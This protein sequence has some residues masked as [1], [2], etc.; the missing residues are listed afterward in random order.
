ALTEDLAAILTIEDQDERLDRASE[1]FA[2]LAE[3][4]PVL[5]FRLLPEQLSSDQQRYWGLP[6]LRRLMVEGALE[7]AVQLARSRFGGELGIQ[8]VWECFSLLGHGDFS[9]TQMLDFWEMMGEGSIRD[10]LVGGFTEALVRK[11]PV[12]AV[13]WLESFESD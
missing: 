4:Q 6:V 7:E 9:L 12:L 3:T 2:K 8:A 1:F 10:Q 11:D 13:K 5:A